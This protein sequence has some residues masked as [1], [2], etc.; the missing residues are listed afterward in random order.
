MNDVANA[1]VTSAPCRL[2]WQG[3]HAGT[4]WI[5][6][7]ALN[8]QETMAASELLTLTVAAA[9]ARTAALQLQ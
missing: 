8:F 7:K 4:V 2:N 9:A 1:G 5:I 6:A 3:A